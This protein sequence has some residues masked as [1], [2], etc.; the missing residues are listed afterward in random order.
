MFKKKKPI[1]EPVKH[2]AIVLGIVI[3]DEVVDTFAVNSPRLASLFL[4][5]PTFID[6]EEKK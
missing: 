6:L 2:P 3:D 5:N 1:E 4:N